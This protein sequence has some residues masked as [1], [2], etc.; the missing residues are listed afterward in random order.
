MASQFDPSTPDPDLAKWLRDNVVKEF[1]EAQRLERQEDP[2]E[3]PYH[4]LYAAR[5]LLSAIQMRLELCP[6]EARETEDYRVVC[7]NIHL[8][9][10]LNYINT[11]EMAKGEE[12]LEECSQLVEGLASKVKT[13]STSLQAYNQLG[14]LWGN[15]GEQ[16]KALEY[17]LKA[18][19]VYDSHIALPPPITFSQ[20]LAGE[21]ESEQQREKEFESLHTHTLFYLAQVFGNLNQPKQAAQYCQQTLSRQLETHEF[22]PLEWSVSCATLSQYYLNMEHYQQARHCLASASRVLEQFSS[23]HEHM[24]ET[25]KEKV[26]QA[27]GD[28]ARCWTKYCIGILRSSR[29]KIEGSSTSEDRPRQK[30]FKF[31]SLEV[32]DLESLV[33]ADLVENYEAAKTMFLFAQKQVEQSKQFY[34]L[35][36][37]ASGYTEVVQDHSLL[38]KL[39]AYFESDDALKCRL[40]KRRVDMLSGTLAE[41]NP[42]HYLMACRQLMFELAEA[43]SEMASLKIVLASEA[44][45]PHAVGKI[46]KLLHASINHFQKFVESFKEHHSNELPADI[47]PDF[48]RPIL[49]A[50]LSTARLYTQIITPSTAEQVGTPRVPLTSSC[51]LPPLCPVQVRC[52][53]KALSH[54]HWLAD[55][56]ASHREAVE[57]VFG[58]EMSVCMEMVE[59]L[60]MRIASLTGGH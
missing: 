44:P 22:D 30:L 25:Q 31:K 29:D 52:I 39:L 2:E 24:E 57:S 35:E 42:Q 11:E 14:I 54:Y 33:S 5:E 45:S 37:L 18:K 38:Y 59:L 27:R 4:S 10:G 49:S 17:L 23:E 34:S 51:T 6:P 55:Y 58:E 53:E 21:E 26:V 48:L 3:E 1:V 13:A 47:D 19:A 40:H 8:H 56:H 36:E 9:L 15:R 12:V 20:W 50:Q 43:H 41:L 16:Q 32:A 28:T 7:A 60:P 46:N